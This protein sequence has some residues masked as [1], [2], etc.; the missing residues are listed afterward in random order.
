M[1]P[2]SKHPAVTGGGKISARLSQLGGNAASKKPKPTPAMGGRGGYDVDDEVFFTHASGGPRSGRVVS[3]GAHGCTVDEPCGKRH[4]VTWDRVLGLKG[5]KT[6]PARVVE[7]GL[8]GSILEREDGTRFFTS[9]D[10][11]V[12]EEPDALTLDAGGQDELLQK[13]DGIA[14]LGERIDLLAIAPA[15]ALPA[16]LLPL[17]WVRHVP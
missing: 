17:L 9:G 2:A 16:G 8:S 4:Q 14:R 10:V 13:A 7:R 6:W 3:H 5:R 15:P 1:K 11:P 12:A